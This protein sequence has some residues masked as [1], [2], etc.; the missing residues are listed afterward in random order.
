MA[1]KSKSAGKTRSSAKK[2]AKTVRKSVKETVRR[3]QPEENAASAGASSAERKIPEVAEYM[4]AFFKF[5]DLDVTNKME[6][7]MN[8]QN[9]QFEQLANEAANAGRE[10]IEAFIKSGTIFAKGMEDI[11]RTAA[12]LS[13]NAA[14]KQAEL[15]K[16]IMGAKTLNELTSAQN[17]IAQA[18]FQEFMSNATRLSEMSVKV[19]NESI[20]PINNQMAKSMSRVSRM[21]A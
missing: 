1:E 16:Q 19:L 6:T 3:E 12:S 7:I 9:F 20:A 10:N 2:P 21:A 5:P 17:K 15:A 8:K 18:N 11:I 14:E 13:Q 4:N